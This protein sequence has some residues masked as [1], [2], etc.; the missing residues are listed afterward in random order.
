MTW[1]PGRNKGGPDDAAFVGYTEDATKHL[2]KLRELGRITT[3]VTSAKPERL[4]AR[5]LDIFTDRG[6]VVLEVFA[7]P[8]DLAATAVKLHRR[9]LMLSGASEGD[10]KT[11][12]EC[13]IPRLRAVV[14]G[15][16]R[17]LEQIEGEIRVRSDDY[18]PFAGGGAFTYARLGDWVVE[19]NR[20]EDLPTINRKAYPSGP[21]QR[22][23]IL[24]AEG[25]MPIIGRSVDGVAWNGRAAAIV[26]P[27]EDFLTAQLAAELVSNLAEE[28]ERLT[29]YYYRSAEEFEPDLTDGSVAFKRVPVEL[30]V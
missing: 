17:D 4:L 25:Y 3:A 26:L 20:D 11:F 13:A 7:G 24:T 8:G 10:R 5:L 9:F 14:Q 2:K 28:Y 30:G 18:I 22:E 16:D 27:A 15:L 6:D 19:R 23:A 1:W 29:V 21:S 12:D